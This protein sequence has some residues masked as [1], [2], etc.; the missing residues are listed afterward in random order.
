MSGPALS[1]AFFDPG[2]RICALS[3]S[4]ATLLFE[5]SSSQV[6]DEPARLEPA[7]DGWEASVEGR[8][9]VR[10][11]PVSEVAELA[12]NRVRVCSATGT[13]AGAPFEGLGTVS[14]TVEPPAWESLDALRALS[15]LASPDHALLAVSRRP[16]GAAG[17]G[18]E[19]VSAALWAEGRLQ[20][21]EEAR[22]STVYDAEGRQRSAGLEL[23]L[24]EEDFPRRASGSVAAGSS[25]ELEGIQVHAAVF[26]W[27]LEGEEAVGQYELAVREPAPD[28]A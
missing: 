20:E 28:A 16:R 2:R 4:A 26:D 10:F 17:H 14:E 7:G 9:A 22:L 21:V 13:V 15:V 8:F 25:L 11:E 23:W 6:L 5:G 3:R 19:L 18:E 27:Q 12:G 1:A 24:A